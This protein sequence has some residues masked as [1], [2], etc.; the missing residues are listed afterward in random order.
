MQVQI[1]LR[2]LNHLRER[3]YNYH[4]VGKDHVDLKRAIKLLSSNYQA[5]TILTD[6]GRILSNLLLDE[7]LVN[8]ISLLIHPVI[9]G[10]KSYNM[11]GNISEKIELKV[12]K[13]EILDQEYLLIVYGVGK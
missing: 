2:F 4:V 13:K 1:H 11:F 7:G 10:D 8:E 6:T 9:V 5:K 12:K 3:E